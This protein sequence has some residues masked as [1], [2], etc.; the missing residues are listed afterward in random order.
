MAAPTTWAV[1]DSRFHAY[2]W[3]AAEDEREHALGCVLAEREAEPGS[4]RG[5]EEMRTLDAE[6]I[7]N[8]DSIANTRWQRI[9]AWLARLVAAALAAVVGE[10][11][12]ELAAQRVGETRRLRD[13]QRIGEAG[14]EEG[15]PAPPESSKYVRTPSTGFVAY[16]IAL[17][18]ESKRLSRRR[19]WAAR[20]AAHSRSGAG[21][22]LR[23][24]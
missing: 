23:Q 21:D 1:G 14:V 20:R 3:V 24:T 18:A 12:A 22:P 19:R 10:D 17:L 16:G 2:G 8:R 5:A 6:H 9:R 7:E 15:G 4:P 11:Q 13:L